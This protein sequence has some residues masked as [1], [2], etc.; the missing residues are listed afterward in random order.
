[1]NRTEIHWMDGVN[2]LPDGMVYIEALPG[3]GNVGKIIVDALI[4]EHESEC[5][6]WIMHPDFPP[7]ST[8]KDGLLR[9]PRIEIHQVLLPM[10]LPVIVLTGD[11]QPLTPTGQY[12]VAD[13][14]L[15]MLDDADSELLLILVGLQADV[16]D[17]SIH[18]VCS[19]ADTRDA[20]A[21]RGV[22]ASTTAPEAGMIGMAG[23]LAGMAPLKGV[24]AACAVAETLGSTVDVI[25]GQRLATWVEE[26]LGIALDISIDTTESTAERIRREIAL[27]T[28]ELDSL[29]NPPEPSPEFY[30]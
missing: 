30:V 28:S 11:S 3:V 1:M 27:D 19:D 9:P 4:E 17:R 21:E 20:F 12:E 25:T 26:K 5:I 29:L 8:M 15:K 18:L 16:E 7:H 24:P 10:G 6:A 23:L 2:S 13:K 14:I 22:T